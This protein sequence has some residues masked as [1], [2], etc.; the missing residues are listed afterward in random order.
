MTDAKPTTYE[1]CLYV[2]ITENDRKTKRE[3]QR[4]NRE[5]ER[6]GIYEDIACFQKGRQ[7]MFSKFHSISRQSFVKLK[8][9]MLKVNS[10]GRSRP[11]S[12]YVLVRGNA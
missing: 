1:A 7:K 12:F 10:A 9:Q 2:S 3:R 4:V 11:Q 5:R 6:G 8:M